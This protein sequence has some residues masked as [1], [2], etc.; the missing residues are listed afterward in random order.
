MSYVLGFGLYMAPSGME[1][2]IGTIEGYNNKIILS[3]HD[4]KLWWN[5]TVNLP[6]KATPY[7]GDVSGPPTHK[8]TA[9]AHTTPAGPQKP[10]KPDI[11]PAVQGKK[12]IGTLG[13]PITI[14]TQ[15][16]AE[17][18]YEKKKK[19]KKNR[20]ISQN[21][22]HLWFNNHTGSTSDVVDT[23]NSHL[24]HINC[25]VKKIRHTHKNEI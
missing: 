7:S 15:K 22:R 11:S 16:Q 24:S 9:A 5:A 19:K 8:S 1:L 13:M 20:T 12:I 18:I 6:A 21:Q 23:Q 10:L 14:P 4:Q 17:K 3:T 2:R 25:Y